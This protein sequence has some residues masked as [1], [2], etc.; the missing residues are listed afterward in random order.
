MARTLLENANYINSTI[1]PAIKSAIIAQGVSV[2]DSDSFLDYATKIAMIG[3]GGGGAYELWDYI[4]SDGTQCIDLGFAP[5]N[6]DVITVSDMLLTVQTSASFM[7]ASIDSSAWLGV[8]QNPNNKTVYS[9]NTSGSSWPSYIS[10]QMNVD[11]LTANRDYSS[12]LCIFGYYQS[13]AYQH[14]ITMR[15]YSVQVNS[16][17]YLPCKRKSDGAFGLW[18]V[19]NQAFL[20]DSAGGNA[21]VGGSKIMDI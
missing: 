5:E 3:G 17:F 18:D 12:N 16:N 9:N 4:E 14:S 20:G 7:W 15:L 11:S 10:D 2:S 1:K 21:F 6:G 19:S 8:V 13:G